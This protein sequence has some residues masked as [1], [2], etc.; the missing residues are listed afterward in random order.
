L[1]ARHKE[2]VTSGYMSFLI[3]YPELS[4]EI[5]K[6]LMYPSKPRIFVKIHFLHLLLWNLNTEASWM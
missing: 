1:Q 6:Y 3:M 4:D 5:T 2:C